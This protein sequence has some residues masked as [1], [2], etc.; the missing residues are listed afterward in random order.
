VG[1]VTSVQSS[2]VSNKVV[3][4]EV[5]FEVFTAVTMKNAVFWIERRL[6]L[7]R[8]LEEPHGVT[9]QKT[10]FFLLILSLDRLKIQ[11][12]FNNMT[13]VLPLSAVLFVA[14]ITHFH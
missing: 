8:N 9:S 5:K 10:A 13:P 2:N 7:V 3:H 1:I 14:F 6:A 12:E 11:N 4:F